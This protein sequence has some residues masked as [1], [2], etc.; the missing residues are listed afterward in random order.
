[1]VV[2]GSGPSL[3]TADLE[4]CRDRGARTIVVNDAYKL[5]PWADCLYAADD[6]WWKWN[7][8]VATFHGLKYT[9]TP[10]RKE[11][12]GLQ[13]VLNAGRDGLE[14]VPTGVRTGS[15]SGYQAVNLA[16]HFGASRIVLLGCDMRGNHFFGSH[17]DGS[18]PPFVVGIQAFETLVEPLKAA[19]V[20]IVNCTPGSAIKAF[21]MASLSD[22]FASQLQEAS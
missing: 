7:E 4:F 5:A 9:I 11:W 22:V 2:A 14:L 20:G 13:T 12:P 10:C 6:K 1:M 16:V 21:R 3:T 15:H 8:G 18:R 17:Q 19:G